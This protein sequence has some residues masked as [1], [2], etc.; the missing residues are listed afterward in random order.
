MKISSTAATSRTAGGKRGDE[1][2]A[3]DRPH[4]IV[5]VVLSSSL[6]P[7]NR[8]PFTWTRAARAAPLEAFD[9]VIAERGTARPAGG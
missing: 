4:G 5:T 9:F 1:G 7:G 3:E 8:G 2:A 6:P